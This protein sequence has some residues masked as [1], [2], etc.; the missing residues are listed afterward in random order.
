MAG[1]HVCDAVGRLLGAEKVDPF[2]QLSRENCARVITSSQTGRV[3]KLSDWKAT[4][5]G[6]IGMEGILPFQLGG[7]RR[8]FVAEISSIHFKLG[9]PTTFHE[10]RTSHPIEQVA[11]AA[12]TQSN[13]S[14]W[15]SAS[16]GRLR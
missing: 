13:L 12:R 6:R 5:Y 7:R 16:H 11:S 1:R 15:H 4:R 10:T 9:R 3:L 14:G 2:V 8:E